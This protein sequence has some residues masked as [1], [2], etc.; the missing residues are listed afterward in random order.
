MDRTSDL[1]LGSYTAAF[2][3]SRKGHRE[4]YSVSFMPQGIGK[5]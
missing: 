3:H 4:G 1:A 5:D 2:M